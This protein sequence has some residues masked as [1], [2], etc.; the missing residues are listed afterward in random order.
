MVDKVDDTLLEEA[1]ENL[2][3]GPLILESAPDKMVWALLEEVAANLSSGLLVD[4]MAWTCT[5]VSFAGSQTFPGL[6]EDRMAW[7]CTSVNFAGSQI[8]PG[9]LEDWMG[10]TCTSVN[11]AGSQTFSLLSSVYLSILQHLAVTT[12]KMHM[13]ATCTHVY[14]LHF[15]IKGKGICT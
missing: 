9:L 6:L 12:S 15:M 4:R 8:F 3:S 11:F 14:V 2:N 7:T 10:W 13:K 5:S 1:V